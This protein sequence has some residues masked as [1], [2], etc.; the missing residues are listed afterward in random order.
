MFLCFSSVNN[1]SVLS[2]VSAISYFISLFSSFCSLS[3]MTRIKQCRQTCK[4]CS[5]YLCYSRQ[6]QTDTSLTA[7]QH[8]LRSAV[9]NIPKLSISIE[10]T[11]P[12]GIL[13]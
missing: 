1:G 4:K 13:L 5:I 3:G 12:K 10:D 11:G 6:T 9:L 2:D 8:P 7:Q